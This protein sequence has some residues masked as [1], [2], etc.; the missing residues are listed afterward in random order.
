MFW[1]HVIPA[2][3]KLDRA[4]THQ[5]KSK[6]SARAV[7]KSAIDMMHALGKTVVAEGLENAGPLS[8]LQ[9]LGRDAMQG[10]QIGRPVPA[11]EFAQ[12]LRNR[13]LVA[14]PGKNRVTQFTNRQS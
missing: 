9:C 8:L 2:A 5:M 13:A 4:C 1:R 14:P 10:Y 3:I 7:V 12:L 6:K 11:G